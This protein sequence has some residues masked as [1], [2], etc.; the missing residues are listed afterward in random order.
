[1]NTKYTALELEVLNILADEHGED[2]WFGETD[3]A[4]TVAHMDTWLISTDG[5]KQGNDVTIY[6]YHNLDPSIYRGVV[7]SLI[8]KNAIDTHAF[9]TTNDRGNQVPMLLIGLPRDTYNEIKSI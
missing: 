7:G 4:D 3:E 1:M 5:L 9:D 2:E 8:K 6:Q